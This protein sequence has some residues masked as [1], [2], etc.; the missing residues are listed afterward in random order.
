MAFV[1]VALLLAA[2]RETR[3]AGRARHRVYDAAVALQPFTFDPPMSAA[4]RGERTPVRVAYLAP[5]VE[6][7]EAPR[8]GAIELPQS[9]SAPEASSGEATLRNGIAY[10]RSRAPMNV[11]NAIRA[12]N[13]LRN[14]PYIFGGGHASFYERGYDCS[15]TVSFALHHAG[16]LETPMPSSGFLSYG[17]RGRGRWITIYSRPGHTFAVIAGLR[18]DTTDFLR[19][20]NTG[21]RWHVDGRDTRGYVAR[22]PAG[23]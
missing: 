8:G 18:L 10:A 4:L 23:F 3:A 7:I 17:E 6:R 22:H 19:G 15:G 5:R 11:K 1:A 9:Q 20:G 14:K 12:V 16:L 13:T 2:V 21:P